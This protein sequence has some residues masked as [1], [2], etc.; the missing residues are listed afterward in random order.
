MKKQKLEYKPLGSIGAL[1]EWPQKIDID[2]LKEIT[3]LRHQVEKELHDVVLDIVPAYNSLSIFFDTGKI[4]YSSVIKK[5][6]EMYLKE[7]DFENT[8]SNLWRI[9]VCYDESFG[10]DL[11]EIARAKK[12]TVKEVVRLHCSAEYKVFFIGFLPGFLYLG[13]LPESIHYKRRTKPRRK[14]ERGAVGIADAQTGI[15]PMESP[16]GW[17]IIGNSPFKFFDVNE[18]PPS[19]AKSGDRIQFYEIDLEEHKRILKAVENGS[20]KLENEV[21]G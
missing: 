10:I 11:E 5:V 16:G 6:E 19:F 3:V 12:L 4:R 1:I 8:D 7:G 15:Y 21:Y 14:V 20:F 2:I 13:G 9:P 18:D 17:N